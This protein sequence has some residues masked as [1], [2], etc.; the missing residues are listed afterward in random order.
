MAKKE[1]LAD[2]K[3]LVKQID[4]IQADDLALY[5]KLAKIGGNTGQVSSERV[6]HSAWVRSG[7]A[8]RLALFSFLPGCNLC[9][10]T[11]KSTLKHGWPTEKVRAWNKKLGLT[12]DP[13]IPALVHSNWNPSLN[14][15]YEFAGLQLIA[16]YGEADAK[17]GC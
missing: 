1:I 17:A 8:E 12:S 5:C 7:Q 6:P 15:L 2:W 14:V 11:A 10:T 9:L 4:A 13:L 3:N 16:A